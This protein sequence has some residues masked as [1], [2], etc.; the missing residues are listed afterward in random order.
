MEQKETELT[1][2]RKSLEKKE[3]ELTNLEFEL[4][5]LETDRQKELLKV[6]QQLK[7]AEQKIKQFE[8]NE[9]MN[10][11]EMIKLQERIDSLT[12]K[13]DESQYVKMEVDETIGESSTRKSKD[14]ELSEMKQKMDELTKNEQKLK[15]ELSLVNE[16]LRKKTEELDIITKDC[17][18][19]KEALATTLETTK[20]QRERIEQLQH[21]LENEKKK[22]TNN[23]ILIKQKEEELNK[24]QENL[25]RLMVSTFRL[26][27]NETLKKELE[28]EILST[29]TYN[30]AKEQIIDSV[31]QPIT[32]LC[33][34][35]SKKLEEANIIIINMNDMTKKLDTFLKIADEM[36]SS[37][38]Y[39]IKVL[40]EILQEKFI[41]LYTKLLPSYYDFEQKR[42][43][44]I[45][46]RDVVQECFYA[47]IFNFSSI[48]ANE[49]Y[50]NNLTN[51][52]NRDLET[53][54][55]DQVIIISDNTKF[56]C[57]EMKKEIDNVKKLIN[58]LEKTEDITKIKEKFK[59]I[60]TELREKTEQIINAYSYA[61]KYERE[62]TNVVGKM[63]KV[64]KSMENDNKKINNKS[65]KGCYM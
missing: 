14:Q 61:K 57:E 8:E 44:F 52:I 31:L 25:H 7:E 36:I 60:F 42:S 48:C 41:Y 1:E 43:I 20:A 37:S 19:V 33:K 13:L 58:G 40:Y 32:E 59:S 4:G 65:K 56:I 55:R 3:K 35:S 29:K 2:S 5:A 24:M 15:D 17:N 26:E 12:H 49:I 23:E 21:E 38:S 51:K 28:D 9:L 10:K 27:L 16:N 30:D 18:A 46:Y 34:F 50:I 11:Q 22:T 6:Q 64:V 47:L 39:Q 63:E 54:I 53:K 45:E 62:L